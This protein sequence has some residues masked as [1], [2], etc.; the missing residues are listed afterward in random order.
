[1]RWIPGA[2][3]IPTV[4]LPSRCLVKFVGMAL[5]KEEQR[6]HSNVRSGTQ[7][8]IIDAGCFVQC[9][10]VDDVTPC[11]PLAPVKDG[12]LTTEDVQYP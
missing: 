5:A 10:P 7:L 4:I 2:E 8:D 6:T 9:V 11:R 3:F 1:M 12:D